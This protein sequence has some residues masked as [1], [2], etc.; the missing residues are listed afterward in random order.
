[1][2]TSNRTHLD[3]KRIMIANFGN[4]FYITVLFPFA[5]Y[6]FTRMYWLT[7]GLTFLTLSAAMDITLTIWALRQGYSEQNYYRFFIS[8]LGQKN[9]IRVTVVVNMALR[10]VILFLMRSDPTAL[11]LFSA[12]SFVGPLWN[13]LH[14]AS[15]YDDTV[16]A[17]PTTVKFEGSETTIDSGYKTRLEQYKDASDT[18]ETADDE[19]K[20]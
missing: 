14:L 16:M 2:A 6:F 13:A 10:V 20:Q 18:E 17:F 19:E 9:G 7:F 12:G 8:R 15:F 1:M 11:L 4:L 3:D 5:F